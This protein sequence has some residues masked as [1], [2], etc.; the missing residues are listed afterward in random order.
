MHITDDTLKQMAASR[1]CLGLPG[2][3]GRGFRDRVRLAVLG[4]FDV[5][6]EQTLAST[7]WMVERGLVGM[8]VVSAA[9]LA[10]NGINPA[11]AAVCGLI[12]KTA[13]FEHGASRW[14]V[15]DRAF[16]TPLASNHAGY[17]MSTRSCFDGLAVM[18]PSIAMQAAGRPL[19]DVLSHPAIDPLALTIAEVEVGRIDSMVRIVE[20]DRADL[21]TYLP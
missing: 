21:M 20:P 14:V 10:H 3:R 4:D 19:R 11:V 12:G 8:D 17:W 1:S 9:I 16:M 5:T 6:T 2:Y 7:R 13:G 18:P 15:T